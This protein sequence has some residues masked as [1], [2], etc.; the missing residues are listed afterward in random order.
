MGVKWGFK[1]FFVELVIQQ[2]YYN[3]FKYGFGLSL[4]V[5]WTSEICRL[6]DF[7]SFGKLWAIIPS[8]IISV[9]LSPSGTSIINYVILFHYVHIYFGVFFWYLFILV[10]CISICIF[11]LTCF[12]F[13]NHALLLCLTWLLLILPKLYLFFYF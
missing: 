12:Q 13:I 10:L 3:A 11:L 8:N 4:K 9:P 5:Y 7:I 1:F 2:F 6:M